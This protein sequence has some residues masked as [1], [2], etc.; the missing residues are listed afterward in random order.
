M[1]A[2]AF[3]TSSAL[4][5]AL[6]PRDAEGER[7]QLLDTPDMLTTLAQ[8]LAPRINWASTVVAP[9][10]PR[11]GIAIGSIGNWSTRT[12]GG[13]ANGRRLDPWRRRLRHS[14]RA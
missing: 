7:L 1:S 11:P 6:C 13:Q 4:L 2:T 10:P 9:I 5:S 8:S 12:R 14:G 3:S